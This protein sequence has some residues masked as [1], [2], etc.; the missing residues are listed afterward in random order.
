M[1]SRIDPPPIAVTAANT[2]TPIR[3]N[4]ALTATSAPVAA[5]VRVPTHTRMETM[6]TLGAYGCWAGRLVPFVATATHRPR[7]RSI[8][9]EAPHASHQLPHRGGPARRCHDAGW[10]RSHRSDQRTVRHRLADVG[11]GVDR[12][13]SLRRVPRVA[14]GRPAAPPRDP[15]PVGG[16]GARTAAD[17][18]AQDPRRRTQLPGA[19]RRSRREA[20]GRTR[21]VHETRHHHHRRG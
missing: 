4:L 17:P 19:R 16:L 20:P 12:S 9:L 18:P 3:S 15:Y 5:N 13:G 10:R 7:R 14:R 21:H 1:T 8:V 11:R 2:N 6:S